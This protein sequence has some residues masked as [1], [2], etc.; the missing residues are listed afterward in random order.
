LANWRLLALDVALWAVPYVPN[1]GLL[2][3]AGKLGD[4]KRILVVGENSS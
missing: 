4:A 3:Q 1:V 2:R